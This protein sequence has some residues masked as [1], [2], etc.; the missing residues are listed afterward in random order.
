MNYI[1]G[2]V[3]NYYL[4]DRGMIKIGVNKMCAVLGKITAMKDTSHEGE[5]IAILV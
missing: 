5:K 4:F 1:M 2:F 3:T